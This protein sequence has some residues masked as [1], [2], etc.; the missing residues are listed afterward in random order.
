MMV[1]TAGPSITTIKAGNMKNT[2]GGT[3]FT[4]VLAL[5]SSAR[6]RRFI[7]KSSE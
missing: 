4:V 5:I 3:I 7:L 1:I 6:W 2:S